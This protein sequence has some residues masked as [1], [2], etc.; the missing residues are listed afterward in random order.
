MAIGICLYL[1]WD[2]SGR[3]KKSQQTEEECRSQYNQLQLSYQEKKT[4]TAL[5]EKQIQQDKEKLETLKGTMK[6]EFENLSQKIFSEKTSQFKQESKEQLEH[7]LNPLKERI[8]D[9]QEKS[10]KQYGEGSKEIFSL[11][12]E[13]ESLIK[14]NQQTN[15]EAQNLT[16]A[17]KGNVKTQGT[18]GESIL[19]RVL[20]ASGLREGEEYLTQGKGMNL[21]S[22]SGSI[23]K[24]DVVVRLPQSRHLI[25]DAKVSLTHYERL[26]HST[27]SQ[28]QE[29][30]LKSFTTSIRKHISELSLKQ[31]QNALNL[32]S[33]DFVFLFFPIESAF[34]VALQADSD[35][36]EFAWKES[37]VIVSPTTLLATLR[38]VAF[39]WQRD[40]ER[41]NAVEISQKAGSLYDKFVG[42]VEDLKQVGQNLEKSSD[43][44]KEAY[45]KLSTGKGNI[46]SRLEDIRTLGARTRKSIPPSAIHPDSS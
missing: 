37:V 23:L 43:S 31:Y 42:F 16:E 38:T 10:E 24:P 33:L 5:L 29:Q 8:K 39:M 13:I 45:K 36:T 34:S 25:I 28:E 12:N 1:I 18:W 19:N 11:K 44:Y 14:A 3:L 4:Q 40:K 46:I 17:L 41:T 26:I 32:K 30:L 21:K 35:I 7:L 15:Q 20:E 27:D 22:E 2:L 6:M 9:F